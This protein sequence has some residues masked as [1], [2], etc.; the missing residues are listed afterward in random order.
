MDDTGDPCFDCQDIVPV[1]TLGKGNNGHGNNEDWVDSSNPGNSKEGEDTS[2]DP[3]TGEYIDDEGRI[4][5]GK[6]S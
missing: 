6:K 5:R 1:V 2:I 3:E 4:K